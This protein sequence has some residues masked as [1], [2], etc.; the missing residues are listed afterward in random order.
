M[1][2]YMESIKSFKDYMLHKRNENYIIRYCNSLDELG[3]NN[4]YNQMKEPL[5]FIIDESYLFYILKWIL[6]FPYED[7][8]YDVYLEVIM[9][10]GQ[11]VKPL[12][13][14]KWH[15]ILEQRY[16]KKIDEFI[17][18]IRYSNNQISN[19]LNDDFIF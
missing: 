4:F 1:K 2:K 3:W 10:P 6:K 11:I 14:T 5:E 12:I 17:N 7:L 9:N 13:T 18:E 16:E 15:S 8:S 19:E